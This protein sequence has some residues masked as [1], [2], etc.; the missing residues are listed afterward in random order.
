MYVLSNVQ[1]MEQDLEHRSKSTLEFEAWMDIAKRE[2][3]TAAL[4]PIFLQKLQP[5]HRRARAG[6]VLKIVGLCGG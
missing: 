6:T 2:P 5:Y 1:Q 4:N 3:V